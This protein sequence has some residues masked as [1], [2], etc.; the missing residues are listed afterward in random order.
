MITAFIGQ[1]VFVGMVGYIFILAYSVLFAEG[2]LKR[3]IKEL[4][5]K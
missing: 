2:G 3:T 1:M 5:N 4:R